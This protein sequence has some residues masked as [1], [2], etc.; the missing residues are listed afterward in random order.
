M[1]LTNINYI[2]SPSL[3]EICRKKKTPWTSIKFSIAN[4]LLKEALGYLSVI[5]L[6]HIHFYNIRYK[7]WLRLR[8]CLK[9]GRDLLFLFQI[10]KLLIQN[11]LVSETGT[12]NRVEERSKA[13]QRKEIQ[14]NKQTGSS[15]LF[16]TFNN[17]L[18]INLKL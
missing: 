9:S 10:R 8:I 17:L 6:N 3:N 13:K 18:Q 15:L 4:I 12:E 14:I 1:D 5:K 7:I 16:S 11:Q 2:F